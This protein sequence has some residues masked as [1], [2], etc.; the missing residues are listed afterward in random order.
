MK[1]DLTSLILIVPLIL[2]MVLIGTAIYHT[3]KPAPK[4]ENSIRNPKNADYVSEVAFNLEIP[5]EKVTQRQFRKRY[6]ES[7]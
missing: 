2:L 3:V 7:Y 6:H 5:T 4:W 1:R